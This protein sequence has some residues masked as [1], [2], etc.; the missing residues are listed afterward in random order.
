MAWDDILFGVLTGGLYNAGKELCELPAK[1]PVRQLL[2]TINLSY[3][4]PTR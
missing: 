2:I 4:K 1:Q 3:R